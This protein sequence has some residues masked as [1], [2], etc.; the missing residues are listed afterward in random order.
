MSVQPKTKLSSTEKEES[1]R[2]HKAHVDQS[3]SS[4]QPLCTQTDAA[5]LPGHAKEGR[6]ALLLEM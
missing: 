3:S 5:V 6:T 4:L 2:I 1:S